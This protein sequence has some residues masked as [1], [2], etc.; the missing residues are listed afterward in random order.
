[1][2]QLHLITC[3]R[4]KVEGDWW[5]SNPTRAVDRLYF[6]HSHG[7][8][9]IVRGK[10]IP[11]QPGYLYLLPGALG[12]RL[13]KE[14]DAAFDHTFFDFS[15]APEL[16][17]DAER[18]LPLG[19][20]PVFSAA[21]A[22]IDA[23]LAALPDR[24]EPLQAVMESELNNLLL[25]VEAYSGLPRMTD[26]RIA[27]AVAYLQQHCA[28]PVTVRQVAGHLCMEESHFIRLFSRVMKQTPYQY[29]KAYRMEQAFSL[30][31]EGCTVSETAARC[32][33]SSAAAFSHCAKKM[34]GVSPGTWRR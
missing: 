13:E 3:G 20:N 31:Q 7:A 25:L 15:L 21:C 1:M 11:L 30:L 2:G 17:G 18:M 32:G 10:K 28:E 8:C 4:K 23:L 12:Y 9:Y 33:F 24:A 14:P 19:A 16:S 34:S 27:E 6:P 5:I 22:Y 29:L 26:A